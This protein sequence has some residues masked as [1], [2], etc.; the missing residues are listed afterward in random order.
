LVAHQVN[1][2]VTY[3]FVNVTNRVRVVT[4]HYLQSYGTQWENSTA[5]FELDF[6]P[7]NDIH[8]SITTPHHT[9]FSLVGYH[10]QNNSLTYPHVLDLGEAHTAPVGSNVSLTLTLTG[11]TNFKITGLLLCNR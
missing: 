2:T 6:V 8:S 4:V 5:Q 1:A 11:G 3:Q 7:P 10:N 9:E